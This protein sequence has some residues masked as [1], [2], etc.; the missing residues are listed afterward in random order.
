MVMRSKH[1]LEYLYP[2]F[3]FVQGSSYLLADA[4]LLII[5]QHNPYERKTD[6]N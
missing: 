4:N 6:N 5:S 1:V 2:K 3:F